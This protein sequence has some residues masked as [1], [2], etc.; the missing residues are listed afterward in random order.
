VLQGAFILAKG[1]GDAT[2]ARE[3]LSHLRRYLRL[4]FAKPEEER[5]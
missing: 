1:Q 4:L 5:P 2:P 3:A